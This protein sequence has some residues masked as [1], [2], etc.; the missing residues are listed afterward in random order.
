MIVLHLLEQEVNP[1]CAGAADKSACIMRVAEL[2]Y[3][4]ILDGVV[5]TKRWAATL[6]SQAYDSHPADRSETYT[7]ATSACS[8]IREWSML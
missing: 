2:L 3:A 5:S 7:I 8:A 1:R 6:L 4:A